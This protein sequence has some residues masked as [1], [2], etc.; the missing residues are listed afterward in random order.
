MQSAQQGQ[1]MTEYLIASTAF[2][3]I[4]VVGVPGQPG[5]ADVLL[6]AFRQVYANFSFVLSMVDSI[7]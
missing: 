7:P 2:M 4:V 6:T 1:V 3:V 5:V